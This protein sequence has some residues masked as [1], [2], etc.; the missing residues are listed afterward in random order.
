MGMSKK[1]GMQARGYKWLLD[2][3][4]RR[5]QSGEG[6]NHDEAQGVKS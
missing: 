2:L 5:R 4:A 1:E 6:E 3:K